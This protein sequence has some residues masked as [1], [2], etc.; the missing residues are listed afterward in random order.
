MLK[1]NDLVKQFELVVKQE[2]INHNDQ[3]ATTNKRIQK[4][5]EEI[6]SLN[7]KESKQFALLLDGLNNLRKYTHEIENSIDLD[8]KN[9]YEYFEFNLNHLKNDINEIQEGLAEICN[10]YIGVL[11]FNLT[12]NDLIDKLNA[13]TQE[14]L[15]FKQEI[16]F[17]SSQLE[18]KL[19]TKFSQ[20]S[21][22]VETSP[23]EI[24]IIKQELLKKIEEQSNDNEGILKEL[25][26]AKKSI[27]IN[28]KHIEYLVTKIKKLEG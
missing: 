2:I 4:I 21:K 26:L 15:N 9:N 7:L 24:D 3:M 6:E 12:R 28:E 5:Y 27:Y 8:I 20:F 22:Q 25:R 16:L 14:Y 19:D 11:T 13:I 17:H 1:R 18:K 10:D 23:K